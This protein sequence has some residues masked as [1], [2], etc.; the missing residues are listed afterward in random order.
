MGDPADAANEPALAWRRGHAEGGH[1][2]A[3]RWR[4]TPSRRKWA[5][6]GLAAVL[7]GPFA[8]ASAMWQNSTAM[9]PSVLLIVVLAPVIEETVKIAGAAYMAEQRPWLVPRPSALALVAVFSGLTFAVV[10]NLWYLWVL[11][12]HPTDHIVAWRWVFGPLVHGAGSLTAGIGV[13]TMWSKALRSGRSP[14]FSDVQPW[15]ITAAV[16][17]G[18][19]NL[20]AVFL[21]TR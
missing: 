2:F 14:S 7:S 13:A 11:I 21:E 8:I 5:A 12:P 10:E 20:F 18:A 19:Y 4:A 6:M 16:W 15:L 9:A 3:E 1:A 17:H